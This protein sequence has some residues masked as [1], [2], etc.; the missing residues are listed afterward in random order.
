[1]R[2]A[3]VERDRTVRT[4]RL[5]HF[6]VHRASETLCVCERQPGRFRKGLKVSG[7]SRPR[8]LKCKAPKVLGRP[9]ADILRA[10]KRYFAMLWEL[11]LEARYR[12]RRLRNSLA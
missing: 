12:W 2:R 5:H 7:C 6:L 9:S 11:G 1:M 10:D 4:W 3:S 8:C